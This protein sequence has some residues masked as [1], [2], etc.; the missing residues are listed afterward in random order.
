M[1]GSLHFLVSITD[2]SHVSGLQITHREKMEIIRAIQSVGQGH[3]P[4][5]ELLILS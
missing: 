1:L 4:V 2:D 5:H 3:V